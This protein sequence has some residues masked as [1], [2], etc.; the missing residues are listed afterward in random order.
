MGQPKGFEVQNG[1]DMVCLLRRS[2]Y[3]LKQLYVDDM[4]LISK[5]RTMIKEMNKILMTEFDMK[6]LGPTNKILGIRIDRNQEDG[7][8]FLGQKIY[9]E[10]IVKKFS[11]KNSKQTS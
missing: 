8:I 1:K 2:L 6:D 7:S 9:L 3:G 10:K 5:T 11:M 4:L